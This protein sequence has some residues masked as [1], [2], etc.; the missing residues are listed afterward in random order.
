MQW[1]AKAQFQRMKADGTPVGGAI[2][3]LYNPTEYTLSKGVQIAEIPIPGLD[4]PILQYIRGQ[5]ETL[6]I[7]LFFDTTDDGTG[8]EATA[9]TKKTDA[10]YRLLKMDAETHA[11]PI[12][13]FTWGADSFPGHSGSGGLGSLG[14]TG[15]SQ[16]RAGFKG[17]VES[18]RQRFTYFSSLG[19]PLRAVLSL[20]IKE[21]KTLAEMVAE[22]NP[23]SPDRTKAH[24]V[25]QGETITGIAGLAA[26]NPR[27]WRVIAELNGLDDPFDLAPG[28]VLAIPPTA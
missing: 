27:D 23:Q 16:T 3:V 19:V 20:Q 11:P 24:V 10:L 4:S 17:V 14:T 5:T 13:L 12:V 22:F 9:V 2:E 18:V 26:E 7:D 21:Y 25:Q 1:L 8:P 6:T 15:G 28:T